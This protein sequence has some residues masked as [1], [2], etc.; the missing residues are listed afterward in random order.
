MKIRIC[1]FIISLLI[2]ILVLP[3]N[4][5]SQ[6]INVGLNGV[7]GISSDKPIYGFSVNF[8]LYT[9]E[10][11]GIGLYTGLYQIGTEWADYDIIMPFMIYK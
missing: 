10:N 5:Y 3:V 1:V 11:F 9:S 8:N 2:I 4:I 6:E 7:T